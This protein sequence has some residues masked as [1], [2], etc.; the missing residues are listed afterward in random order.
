MQN[1][2]YEKQIQLSEIGILGQEKITKA[3]VLV[4]GAGGLAVIDKNNRLYQADMARGLLRHDA[5]PRAKNCGIT[6]K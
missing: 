6:G 4:I 1:N 5:K 2:R 3:K